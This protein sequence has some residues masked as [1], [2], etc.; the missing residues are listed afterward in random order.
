MRIGSIFRPL[1]RKAKDK[2]IADAR[3]KAIADA[4]AAEARAWRE[5]IES[6]I[7]VLESKIRGR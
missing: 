2:A 6:R 1:G 7:A 4:H 5:M 3:A